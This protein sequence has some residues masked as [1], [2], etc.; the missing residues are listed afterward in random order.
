M[1]ARVKPGLEDEFLARYEALAGRVA[2]GLDGHEVHELARD[3]DDEAC[4]LI[5]SRWRTAEDELAW[6]Q[7]SD[8]RELTAGLRECWESAERHRYE[9]R[10]ETRHPERP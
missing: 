7:S 1:R 3:L 4:W 6:E 8:H 2:Q 9:V 5:T 10:L